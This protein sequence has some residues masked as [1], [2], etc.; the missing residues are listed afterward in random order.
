MYTKRSEL[1]G[2]LV[3]KY[4]FLAHVPSEIYGLNMCTGQKLYTLDGSEKGHHLSEGKL[5]ETKN[6][7]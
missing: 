2:W 7:P 6:H 5:W 3:F 1:V 4:D